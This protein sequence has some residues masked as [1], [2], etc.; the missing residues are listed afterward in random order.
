MANEGLQRRLEMRRKYRGTL[1][2]KITVSDLL[3]IKEKDIID[4][5][6]EFCA[7]CQDEIDISLD[8]HLRAIHNCTIIG[9]L[10][11]RCEIENNYLLV[12][13]LD[14]DGGS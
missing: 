8:D 5:K 12:R 11:N 9:L 14:M 4:D 3:L 7:I 10:E 13:M 2:G 1:S 6:S